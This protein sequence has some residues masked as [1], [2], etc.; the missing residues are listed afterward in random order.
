M[1]VH[2][3]SVVCFNY[4]LCHSLYMLGSVH[5]T[6]ATWHTAIATLEALTHFLQYTAPSHN[7]DSYHAKEEKS[8]LLK[9]KQP[10]SSVALF[11]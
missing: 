10:S 8:G 11:Q 1:L 9:A 2:L 4:Q 7:V 6:P 3:L 5:F